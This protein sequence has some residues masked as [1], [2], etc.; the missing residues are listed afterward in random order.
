MYI[1]QLF[2]WMKRA[3]LTVFLQSVFFAILRL[4]SSIPIEIPTH[5]PKSLNLG[6]LEA[7]ETI[8]TGQLSIVPA[9]RF[10]CLHPQAP[11]YFAVTEN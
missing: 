6:V 11:V 5:C 7:S 3:G 1:L 9:L 4:F 10:W 8:L 2:Y